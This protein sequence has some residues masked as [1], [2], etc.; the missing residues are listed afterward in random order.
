MCLKVNLLTLSL[1]SLVTLSH[2][3]QYYEGFPYLS[4]MIYDGFAFA[5]IV[6]GT[7]CMM[8]NLKACAKRSQGLETI[9]SLSF[10]TPPRVCMVGQTL[11]CHNYET[12]GMN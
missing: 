3:A 2:F 4:V 9:L 10:E 1:V 5:I 11:V 12:F 6:V 7:A 8:A